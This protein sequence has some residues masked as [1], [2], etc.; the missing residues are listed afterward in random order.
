MIL[1]KNLQGVGLDGIIKCSKLT[2]VGYPFNFQLIV[3]STPRTQPTFSSLP[4]SLTCKNRTCSHVR[5]FF[6]Y[7][8]PNFPLNLSNLIH[9]SNTSQLLFF[10]LHVHISYTG[11]TFPYCLLY[12][13]IFLLHRSVL[14]LCHLL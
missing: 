8:I 12:T 13:K 5:L 4:L 10:L 9:L 11:L 7:N 14:L 2:I 1:S 6:I 3:H